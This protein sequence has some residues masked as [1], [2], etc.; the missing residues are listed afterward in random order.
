MCD[1]LFKLWTP[2]WLHVLIF[3][4]AKTRLEHQKRQQ[5]TSLPA[6]TPEL[7]RSLQVYTIHK[8]GLCD[9]HSPA[10]L[11]TAPWSD[12]GMAPPVPPGGTGPIEMVTLWPSSLHRKQHPSLDA[13][14]GQESPVLEL[15][16]SLH[17]SAPPRFPGTA[18]GP[19]Q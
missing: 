1:V 2:I 7:S 16:F 18:S 5:A 13:A 9:F 15:V 10:E 6:A 12:E 11:L 3:C 19:S 4:Q 14:F 8:G 17:S